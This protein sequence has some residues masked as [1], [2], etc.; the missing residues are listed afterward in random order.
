[1]A[2][3]TTAKRVT[4]IITTSLSDG[5]ID[6]NM[7]PAASLLVDEHLASAGHSDDLL[8]VIEMYLAAHLVALTEE[9]GGIIKEMYGDATD[10]FSD[11]YGEGFASTRY[12]QMA[13]ALDTSG[14]LAS[15]TTSTL[16]ASFRVV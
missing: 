10:Q 12:G 4:E 2:I 7:V 14:T 16:K 1:M 6:T 13:L 5:V 11:V 15:A 8:E 9:K 3:R